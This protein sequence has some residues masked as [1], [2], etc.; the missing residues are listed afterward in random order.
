MNRQCAGH[1]GQ[2]KIG[3]KIWDSGD[4]YLGKMHEGIEHGIGTYK[5]YYVSAD[6]TPD[7]IAHYAGE[8]THGVF[9]LHGIYHF[10]NGAIFA[11]SWIDK[12]PRFGYE[13]FF[14]ER[15]DFDVYFGAMT[16]IPSRQGPLWKPHGDGIAVRLRTSEVWCGEFR[17][18]SVATLYGNQP[19]TF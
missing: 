15:Y 6:A 1:V 19:F 16:S 18:G 13:E 8:I 12:H 3:A 9:G 5:I 10:P 11:G 7:H 4:E 14:G 2:N 17:A